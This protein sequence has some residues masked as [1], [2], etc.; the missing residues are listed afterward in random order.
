SNNWHVDGNWSNGI[1]GTT[2]DV[3]IPAGLSNYPTLLSTGA[4]KDI[5]V[6]SS[7]AGTA[8][9]LDNGYL[10]ISGTVTMERYMTTDTYHSFSP[11]VSGATA[12]IFHLPGSTGLDVYL[13]SHSELNNENSTS[14]Y[15]EIHDLSTPL[16][17][18]AGYAVYA[19]GA[20][21]TPPQT[22]WTF[23]EHGGLNT[24]SFGSSNNMTRTGA[25]TT[26]GLNYAG[27]PYPS[28]IDWDAV[29]G[30]T[31]TNVNNAIYI[32]KPGNSGANIGWATYIAGVGV[33]SG[34]R[35]IAPGQGF[36]VEAASSGTL[37]MNNSVRVHNAV[38]YLKSTVNNLV[39]L[40]VSG[41]NYTD[42]AAVRFL[43]EATAQFD[44]NYDAHKLFEEIDGA[45]EIYSLGSTPLAIN[46]LPE[47]ST[48]PL[49]MRVSSEGVYT[50]AAT[51]VNDLSA[52]SLEDTKTG[53][54]TDLLKGSYAFS[55]T[56][57]ENEQRFVLHFGPLAVNDVENSFANIYSYSHTVFVDMKDNVKGDIFIYNIAGQLVSTVTTAMGKSKINLVNTGN[58]IVKVI[59]NNS[60]MVKK[61]FVQ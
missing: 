44:G 8:S 5:L 57:G 12:N 20:E 29:S 23:V 38:P 16:V 15:F 45:A 1:P 47:T 14:G 33:N 28:S 59:T 42:E 18:M 10:S 11:S 50:I 22:A 31:K 46:A 7:A 35:Y 4:C 54:F 36:F 55:F 34:S 41:N 17:P 39:R 51:E 37:M 61:V 52:V 25:L 58:Y 24:G 2:T 26:A 3:T 56:P 9:L 6:G 60:T 53:I 43:P 21:A 49:G 40:Q 30:W 27:N 13:Y 32:E 19:K 48:V